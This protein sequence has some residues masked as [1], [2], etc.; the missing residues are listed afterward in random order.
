MDDL[1]PTNTN[2]PIL[3]CMFKGYSCFK[4]LCFLNK[5]KNTRLTSSLNIVTEASVWSIRIR[6]LLLS[7][8]RPSPAK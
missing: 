7:W 8:W 5:L 1:E 3:L 2:L 6:K 4:P